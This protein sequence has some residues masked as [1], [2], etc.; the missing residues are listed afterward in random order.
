MRYFLFEHMISLGIYIGAPVKKNGSTTLTEP[1]YTEHCV[2]FPKPRYVVLF[3]QSSIICAG[4][5]RL[6]TI[7]S[8]TNFLSTN[9]FCMKF[10]P[11]STHA[12]KKPEPSFLTI[13]F[14]Y[15]KIVFHD[16]WSPV[17]KWVHANSMLT[18]NLPLKISIDAGRIPGECL[19]HASKLNKLRGYLFRILGQS[20]VK[21]PNFPLLSSKTLYI[22]NRCVFLQQC[23]ISKNCFGTSKEG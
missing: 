9:E 17:Q 6:V 2:S 21:L 1:A 13:C 5:N 16:V 8:H 20:R 14:K 4:I 22:F 23:L 19:L 3:I 11:S 18:F 12:A 7:N 10:K 15:I